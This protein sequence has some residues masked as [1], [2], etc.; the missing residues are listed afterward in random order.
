MAH[1]GRMAKNREILAGCGPGELR[2]R[3]APARTRPKTITFPCDFTLLILILT[4]AKSKTY[5]FAGILPTG[6]SL[7]YRLP[8]RLNS[9]HPGR[10]PPSRSLSRIRARFVRAMD[11]TSFSRRRVVLINPLGR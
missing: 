4:E 3:L 5:R 1:N 2:A 8:V 11:L 7:C 10:I 9:T 6:V